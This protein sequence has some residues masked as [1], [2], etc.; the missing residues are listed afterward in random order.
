MRRAWCLVSTLWLSAA[1]VATASDK[2]SLHNSSQLVA[3]SGHLH[4]ETAS[5]DG[6][7]EGPSTR[8]LESSE[9]SQ[10]GAAGAPYPQHKSPYTF[11][12]KFSRE[13]Y[14]HSDASSDDSTHDDAS[15]SEDTWSSMAEVHEE[16]AVTDVDRMCAP[17]QF[18][19]PIGKSRGITDAADIRGAFKAF[20]RQ[21]GNGERKLLLIMTAGSG[22][23]LV[24]NRQISQRGESLGFALYSCI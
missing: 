16:E 24:G 14:E 5:S 7:L 12:Q 21:K 10:T 23:E 8:Y 2:E 6:G 3:D 15:A 22:E 4:P 9:A 19:S 11:L 1:V 13:R 17:N 18:L 20:S